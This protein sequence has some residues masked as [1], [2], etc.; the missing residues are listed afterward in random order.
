MLTEFLAN[1]KSMLLTD[2]HSPDAEEKNCIY[3]FQAQK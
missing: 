1:M 2:H 3:I